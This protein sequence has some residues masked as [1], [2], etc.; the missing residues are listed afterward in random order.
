MLVL[1]YILLIIGLGAT[2][3][4]LSKFVKLYHN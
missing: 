3:D 2:D 1:T 4:L